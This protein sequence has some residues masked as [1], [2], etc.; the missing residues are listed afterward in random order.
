MSDFWIKRYLGDLPPYLKIMLI[1][2]NANYSIKWPWN[3]RTF[4]N[5]DKS[6]VYNIVV[7]TEDGM[8]KQ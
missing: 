6:T 3:A 1:I 5:N 8:S 7:E 2:N 4:Q